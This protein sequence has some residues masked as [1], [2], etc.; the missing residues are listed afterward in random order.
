M[1]QDALGDR[2]KMLED[3]E[4]GRRFLPGL[5]IYARIDGR[6]FSKFTRGMQRPYDP[7]M[8]AA[9]VGATKV[10]VEQTQATI[11][12]V[13]SD[14]ISLVWIPTEHGHGW[15]DGK[16]MKMTSVLAGLASSAFISLMFQHFEEAEVN[17]LMARLP[18]F[19]ARV[20][21]VPSL[22]EAA[23][24][25]LWRNLD[26]TKNSLSMAA[27]HY[28]SHKQ[29][30]GKNG[31]DKHEMLFEKGVNFNLYPYFFKRG[32][33]IKRVVEDRELSQAELDRIPEHNRPV[34][35]TVVTRSRV[36]AYDL[37][38][39]NKVSN[40]VDVLFKGAQPQGYEPST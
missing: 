14:E 22:I 2:M 8:S 1:T 33:W 10:L 28:Y 35:G 6:G 19:D 31:S 30:H 40:R 18:H 13:Q 24:M 37:P 21:S 4:T 32:T 27:S 23:N 3:Q 12:Y 25:L 17:N 15:F 26:S 11:G 20:I 5:P 16:V 34:P 29:L 36:E 7:R 9:M 39:L 38:P